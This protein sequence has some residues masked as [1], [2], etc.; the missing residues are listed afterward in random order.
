VYLRVGMSRR[1]VVLRSWTSSGPGRAR[2]QR[3]AI[4]MRRALQAVVRGAAWC[5]IPLPK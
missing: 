3:A 4:D 1:L 5:R 2:V